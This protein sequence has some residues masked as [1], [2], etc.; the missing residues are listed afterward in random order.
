[1]ILLGE[2][3]VG[4][5]CLINVIAGKPFDQ[6]SPATVSSNYYSMEI[7]VNNKNYLCDLWDTPGVEKL[8]SFTKI[9]INN[10]KIVLIVFSIDSKQT[11]KEVDFWVKCSKEVLG[12]D[13]YILALVAN[14]SDRYKEEKVKLEDIK[15]KAEELNVIINL[16]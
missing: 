16:N 8:R 5:T 2:S 7:K 10:S 3:D 1:M 6:Q 12:T 11:F 14:K 9:F 4:K 15:K 13:G